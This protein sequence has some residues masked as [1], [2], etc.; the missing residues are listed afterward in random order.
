MRLWIDHRMKSRADRWA[1]FV[2]RELRPRI[3]QDSSVDQIQTRRLICSKEVEKMQIVVRESRVTCWSSSRKA[4]RRARRPS[5][6]SVTVTPRDRNCDSPTGGEL[7]G[8]APQGTKYNGIVSNLV[9][10]EE[11]GL[12]GS[13]TLYHLLHHCYMSEMCTSGE[14]RE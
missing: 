4:R 7:P 3:P 6:S 8:S 11:P 1:R 10:R 2:T 12:K 14:S 13:N 9:S 5:A